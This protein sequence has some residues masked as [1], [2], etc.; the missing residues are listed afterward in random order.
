MELLRIVVSLAVMATFFG[1]VWWAYAP[2]RKER[3]E[4]K[5]VL[6]EEA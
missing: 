6:E 4:Q 5:G 2:S 3:W 1:I